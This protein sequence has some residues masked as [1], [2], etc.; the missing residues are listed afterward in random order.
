ME[1]AESG[2]S[3]P[4]LDEYYRKNVYVHR[5]GG[6][7]CELD[8]YHRNYQNRVDVAFRIMDMIC[9]THGVEYIPSMKLDHLNAGDYY[10]ATVIYDRK[11]G[12]WK[13]MSIAP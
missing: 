13:V 2:E 6:L 7:Y 5:P 10:T 8:Y 9:E 11:T 1:W 3:K 12:S 4:S